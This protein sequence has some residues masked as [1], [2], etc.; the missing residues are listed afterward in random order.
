MSSPISIAK[1][2][3]KSIA[4][5]KRERRK[6]RLEPEEVKPETELPPTAKMVKT[7]EKQ[8]RLSSYLEEEDEFREE[9]FP[10]LPRDQR[11]IIVAH[12]IDNPNSINF[13]KLCEEL[14]VNHAKHFLPALR[15]VK[16]FA[17]FVKNHIERVRANL[18]DSLHDVALGKTAKSV[19]IAHAK[20][21][22]ELITANQ[23]VPSMPVGEIPK[24]GEENVSLTDSERKRLGYG[25]SVYNRKE[26]EEEPE[27]E[28]SEQ[29]TED[30]EGLGDSSEN[31]SENQ[32]S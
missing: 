21:L 13:F 31:N 10:L 3:S 14:A 30:P 15:E 22:L 8:R 25:S 7:L 23:V 28:I 20:L 6:K 11:L 24:G 5:S 19:S 18:I 2:S 12:L 16:P 27:G 26:N 4:S 32:T 1:N 9:P 17:F 29:S